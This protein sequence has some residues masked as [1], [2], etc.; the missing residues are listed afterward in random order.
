MTTPTPATSSTH[1]QSTKSPRDG[2]QLSLLRN[3]SLLVLGIGHG[4]VDLCGTILPIFYPMLIGALGLSYASVAALTTVQSVTSSVSQPFLGWLSDRVG[5]RAVAPLSVLLAAGSIALVG[6]APRYEALLVLVA[7]MG[8]GIGSYHPQGAKAASIL[9]GRWRT[10]GLS[11]YMFF[12]TAGL[13]I[14][15]LLSSM[16]LVPAGLRSTALLI[17]PG[18][19]VGLMLF[20][21]MGRVDRAV[22]VRAKVS[23]EITPISIAW[24]GVIALGVVI[25][26]R[27]WVEYGILAFL[28]LLYSS[29]GEPGEMVGGTLSLIMLMMGVGT[30]G[31]GWIADKVGKVRTLAVTFL[32]MSLVVHLFLSTSGAAATMLAVLMGF[33]MGCPSTITL[34][35]VQEILPSRMGMASGLAISLGMI[36]GGVGVW[37]LGVLADNYGL[38]LSMES[39]VLAALLACGAALLLPKQKAS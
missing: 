37:I 3:S 16:V 13:S 20:A 12:G 4:M 21:T 29:R 32:A 25:T 28:P 9:G 26:I 22:T 39:M 27:S 36:M 31:G 6:F 11:I 15:P 17:I 19:L 7:L 34:A 24:G 10:T 35:A 38:L 14:A 8:L 5:S 30:V 23:Q 1:P 18:L 33:L 2:G